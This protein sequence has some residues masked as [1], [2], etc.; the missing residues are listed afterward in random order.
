[1]LISTVVMLQAQNRKTINST[2]KVA[3]S[4]KIIMTTS[5]TRSCFSKQ[6]QTCKTKTDFFWSQTGLVLRPTV[7]D[8]ITVIDINGVFEHCVGANCGYFEHIMWTH[9]Q[10]PYMIC[11][12]WLARSNIPHFIVKICKECWYYAHFWQIDR[13][14]DR[15][16]A[17]TTSPMHALHVDAR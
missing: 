3:V 2:W 9:S 17:I 4:F 8:H 16:K 10:W 14:T 12:M 15:E 13:Q 7:S 5:V 1:M 6:H 11:S